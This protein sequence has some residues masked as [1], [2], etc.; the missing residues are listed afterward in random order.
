MVLV[1][2]RPFPA[3]LFRAACCF[4]GVAPKQSSGRRS[5]GNSSGTSAQDARPSQRQVPS[6]GTS[7]RDAR[8]SRRQVP[9]GGTSTP[10]AA[11]S[12]PEV[13][14]H[15]A[16]P[17]TQRNLLPLSVS[18]ETPGDLLRRCPVLDEE[19]L[20]YSSSSGLAAWLLFQ[21]E[22]DEPP[23]EWLTDDVLVWDPSVYSEG[24]GA[25][26]DYWDYDS[27][28]SLELEDVQPLW[29]PGMP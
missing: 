1:R 14:Q 26:P 21:P 28:T 22:S 12:A 10:D 29:A 15:G 13:P 17:W 5:P 16:F 9:L 3:A 20:T 23:A 24:Y 7:L 2:P 18:T 6:D 19:E 11:A 27:W 8:P 25:I 4:R